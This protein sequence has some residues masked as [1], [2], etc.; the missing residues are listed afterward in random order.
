MEDLAPKKNIDV[1]V[2]KQVKGQGEKEVKDQIEAYRENKVFLPGFSLSTNIFPSND[3]AEVV[4]EKDLVLIVVPS[5]VMRETA[6]KMY[7]HISTKTIIV[8]ASKGI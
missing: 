6:Q 5:H 7:R 4:A 2:D 8:S 3:I 1:V